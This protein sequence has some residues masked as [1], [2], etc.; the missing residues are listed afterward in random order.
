MN[1][2]KIMIKTIII[3]IFLLIVA[4]LPVKAATTLTEFEKA[5]KEVAYAYYMRGP[6]LQYNGAKGTIASPEEATSQDYHYSGCAFYVMNVFKE[7]LD[8]DLSHNDVGYLKYAK[9]Y[10]GERQE[11]IG[12]GHLEDNGDL[13]WYDGS[14]D[15]EGNLNHI[16]NPSQSYIIS[17]LKIGDII[18][19]AGHVMLV[20]DYI[21]DNNGNVTDVYLIH[22]TTTGNYYTR[23]KA[24]YA[25]SPFYYYD[26]NGERQTFLSTYTFYSRL[27]YINHDMRGIFDDSMIEGTIQIEPLKYRAENHTGA[28]IFDK[29]NPK[30]NYSSGYAILRLVTTDNEGNSILNVNCDFSYYN[31]VDNVNKK[32]NYSDSTKSRIKYSK[33]FIEKTVDKID[34]NAVTVNDHLTYKI[35]IKNN[36]EVKY[37][38]DLLVTENLSEYVDFVSF[39]CNKANISSNQYDNKYEWNIGK[40]NSGEEVIIQYKVNVKPATAGRT[41]ISTGKVANIPS[42]TIKNKISTNIKSKKDVEQSYNTLKTSYSGRNLINEIYKD[43]YGVDLKLE[44]FKMVASGKDSEDGLLYS[45]KKWGRWANF[46]YDHYLGIN[47]NNKFS[48]MVLGGYFNILWKSETERITITDEN[49]NLYCLI[50]WGKEK[51]NPDDRE[52]TINPNVFKTGD[53]LVY[54]NSND[55]S[56]YYSNGD[57]R[58]IKRWPVTNEDGEYWYIFIEGKGFVGINNGNDLTSSD[59][60]RN[61]FNLSYYDDNNNLTMYYQGTFEPT[62]EMTDS[63]KEWMAYQTLF[64][65]DNYVILRPSLKK[66]LITPNLTVTYDITEPTDKAVTVTISSDKL[67]IP[68]PGWLLSINGKTLTKTYKY[69]SKEEVIVTDYYGSEQ[70]IDIEIK[71]ILPVVASDYY[72]IKNNIIS[73]VKP[74]TTFLYFRDSMQI[75]NQ[76]SLDV[77]YNGSTITSSD[78]IRNGTKLIVTGINGLQ[79]YTVIVTGDLNE[80]GLSTITDLALVQRKLLNPN[81]ELSTNAILAGD[82]DGN[83]SINIKDLAAIQRYIL[84]GKI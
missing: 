21:Y 30:N 58:N 54:N 47:K 46:D 83:G 3:L 7:L 6:S 60:D 69:N 45:N 65:K 15:S 56:Y 34:N 36:S 23:S 79:E 62:C 71:N 76:T 24:D 66:D 10:V 19:Y 78:L 64:G 59:D 26:K 29:D 77:T 82:I 37:E 35:I 67:L 18:D 39:E 8:I 49:L 81:Y 4:A 2:N 13:Y 61:E 51:N 38:D 32:V 72:D 52:D 5:F 57:D 44:D 55:Y 50:G 40:L 63:L 41:I 80:D 68:I 11:V 22:S 53:I 25:S 74:N 75:R 17:Q 33:L 48:D 16:S 12:Y 1:N 9:D 42:G 27:Y 43:A 20:Y 73:N 70:T 31:G 28:L 14:K 84:I